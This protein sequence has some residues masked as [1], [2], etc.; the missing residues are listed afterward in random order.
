MTMP[1]IPEYIVKA[2]SKKLNVTQRELNLMSAH[3][4]SASDAMNWATSFA[5][6]LNE[7]QFLRTTD[8]VGQ[9][10]QVDKTYYA[11]TK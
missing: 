9:I 8:W 3:P 1:E 10:E 5:T 11:R 4:N 2:Y 6:R 7:Q